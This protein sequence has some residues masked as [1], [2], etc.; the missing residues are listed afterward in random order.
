[1]NT[2][3][4]RKTRYEL[5]IKLPN[6]HAQTCLKAVDGSIKQFIQLFK[7]TTCDN[8]AEFAEQSQLTEAT[9]YYAHPSAPWK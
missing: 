6:Y 5:V 7:T 2:L 8:G 3:I 9:S 4:E 1:M